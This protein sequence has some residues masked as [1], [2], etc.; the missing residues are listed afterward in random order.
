MTKSAGR[1]LRKLFAEYGDKIGFVTLYVREA[2][3][4]NRYP[5][6]RTFEQ[7]LAHARAYADRDCITWPVAVDDL[8]GSLHRALDEKPN[9][10][11]VMDADGNVAYRLLWSNGAHALRH[12]LGGVLSGK[13]GQTQARVAPMLRGAAYLVETLKLAGSRA[14]SDFRREARPAWRLGRVLHVLRG[15]ERS[16]PS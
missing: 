6:P 12:A 13:H 4:G 3:P 15:R 14:V 5:Q 8:D 16:V 7:K 11:Y 1:V 10:A 9:A 2:H